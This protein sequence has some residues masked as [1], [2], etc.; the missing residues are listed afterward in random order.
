VARTVHVTPFHVSA[1]GAAA[2]MSRFLSLEY[3]TAAHDRAE[4]HDTPVRKLI[5]SP[6]GLGTGWV[7][8]LRPFQRSASGTEA[9]SLL[10]EYPTAVHDR[11][12]M[13]DT[14]V[15]RLKPSTPACGTGWVAHLRPFQRSASGT[16]EASSLTEYPTA[17]H[18]RS[19][20]HDTP[21]R[22]F[23]SDAVPGVRCTFHLRP[24]QCT[25]TGP[26]P[27]AMHALADVHDTAARA[28]LPGTRRS[29]HLRPFQRSASGN[30]A[31]AW[32]R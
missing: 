29:A 24:F 13:H 21:V 23:S 31:R 9:S 7:A 26:G 11:A 2:S 17:V 30:A 14:P 3:P 16:P 6:A 27:T 4:A 25:A 19:D 10:V 32:L 8:H 15:K 20:V 5:P 18:A 28:P 1:I 22:P 12:E